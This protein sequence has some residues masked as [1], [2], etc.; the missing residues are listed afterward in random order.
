MPI[1]AK[2]T[3]AGSGTTIT[4]AVSVRDWVVAPEYTVPPLELLNARVQ[5]LLNVPWLA[6]LTDPCQVL[7]VPDASELN[8]VRFVVSAGVAAI[9]GDRQQRE[10]GRIAGRLQ[11]VVEVEILRRDDFALV[12]REEVERERRGRGRPRPEARD[13]RIEN[14]GRKVHRLRAHAHRGE[15]ITNFGNAFF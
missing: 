3:A 8:V 9:R 1:P 11:E 4:L 13:G 10:I 12:H 7:N 15:D 6:V 2:A 14:R 5:E